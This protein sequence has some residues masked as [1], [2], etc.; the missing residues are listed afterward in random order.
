MNN[1]RIQFTAIMFEATSNP[2]MMFLSKRPERLTK[3]EILC[4]IWFFKKKVIN[5]FT[6]HQ[7]KVLVGRKINKKKTNAST[8][9]K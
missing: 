6:L 7:L 4:A 9:A 5:R 8:G 2:L 3:I 1:R